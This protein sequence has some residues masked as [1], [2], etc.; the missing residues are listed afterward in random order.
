LRANGTET[1]FGHGYVLG[2]LERMQ[3]AFGEVA[4]L[5]CRS[6]ERYVE[7]LPNGVVAMGAMAHPRRQGHI[8][9]RMIKEWGPTHL[10]VLGPMANLIRWGIVNRCRVFAQFADSFDIPLFLRLRR[11]GFLPSLLND[12]R[13]EWISNHGFNAC[14]S[15]QRIG[16]GPEKVLPWDFPHQRRPDQIEPR[17]KP[18]GGSQRLLYVGTIQPAK[19]IGDVIAAIAE[20]ARRGRDIALDVV[21]SGQVERFRAL[22]EK[23]GIGARVTFIGTIPNNEVFERMRAATAVVVPS[24]HDYPEGLPLTIYEALCARAPII[25]SDHPMFEGHLVHGDTAMVFPAGRS[26]D[27]AD[28]VIELLDTAGLYERLSANAQTAWTRMQVTS[29]WG[30]LLFRWIND[31]SD[32]RAWL[33]AQTIDHRARPIS[34]SAP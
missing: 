34:P 10:V 28:R 9:K 25:A 20:L 12:R 15:L 24:H 13:V 2:E 16:V 23:L 5:C 3:R 26:T 30:E 8:V 31:N 17:S 22:S 11:Y 14:R 33:R 6:N 29:K 7:R 18:A 32:D 4:I 1:Y 27:L 21:G 19:G